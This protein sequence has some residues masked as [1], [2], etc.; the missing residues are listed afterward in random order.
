V[1]HPRLA[2][3]VV[4]GEWRFSLSDQSATIAPSS[5]YNHPGQAISSALPL[6][7]LPDATWARSSTPPPPPPPCG[8]RGFTTDLWRGVA[9]AHHRVGVET[10][11]RARGSPPEASRRRGPPAVFWTQGSVTRRRLPHDA[12]C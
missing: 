7:M 9:G 8:A 1:L 3:D 4:A 2:H 6:P 11:S 5:A 12:N 10:P